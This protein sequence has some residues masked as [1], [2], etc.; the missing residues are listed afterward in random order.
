MFD[1]EISGTN[2][3]GSVAFVRSTVRAPSLI[4]AFT[5]VRSAVLPE[6]GK[7]VTLHWH[8]PEGERSS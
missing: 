6:H 1:Y 7:D 2:R 3:D 8:A 4:R 5:I